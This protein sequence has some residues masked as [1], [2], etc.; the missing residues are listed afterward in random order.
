MPRFE[1]PAATQP[2]KSIRIT[3]PMTL[4]NEVEALAESEGSEPA[5]VISYAVAFAF[6]TRKA[7]NKGTRRTKKI[8]EPKNI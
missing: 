4:W 5:T 7:A 6:E 8:A 2:P 3:L 1:I